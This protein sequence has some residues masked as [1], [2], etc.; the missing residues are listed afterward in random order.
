M[1]ACVE[2]GLWEEM[3]LLLSACGDVAEAE[4]MLL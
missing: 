4:Y 3:S 2:Y 1:I